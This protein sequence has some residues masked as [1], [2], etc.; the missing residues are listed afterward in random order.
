M[1]PGAAISPRQIYLCLDAELTRP[2]LVEASFISN[3]APQR[4][5]EASAREKPTSAN[6]RGYDEPIRSA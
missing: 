3:H 5:D 1:R 6:S 2:C 4:H